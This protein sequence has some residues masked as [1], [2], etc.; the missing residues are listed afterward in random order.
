MTNALIKNHRDTQ[1][2]GGHVM[3]EADW[4]DASTSQEAPGIAGNHQE[5]GRS[6]EGFSPRIFREGTAL[7]APGFQTSGLQNC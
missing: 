7:S 5:L 1:G 2:E 6:K 4:S 3:M